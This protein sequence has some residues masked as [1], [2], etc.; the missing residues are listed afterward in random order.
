MVRKWISVCFSI[1][2]LLFAYSSLFKMMGYALATLE[3]TT[4]LPLLV[5]I[6]GILP[7]ML[8]LAT[9]MCYVGITWIPDTD[10]K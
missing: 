8:I 9:I 2:C 1:F 5:I 3:P 10:T 7:L 6:F 4:D